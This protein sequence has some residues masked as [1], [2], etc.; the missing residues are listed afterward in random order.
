MGID[1][2]TPEAMRPEDWVRVLYEYYQNRML[3]IKYFTDEED[4]VAVRALEATL[5]PTI[6]MYVDTLTHAEVQVIAK[7]SPKLKTREL[8]AELI[9][10][11]IAYLW[12]QKHKTQVYSKSEYERLSSLLETVARALRKKDEPQNGN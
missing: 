2:V 5:W 12:G 8:S 11:L 6:Q 10:Q 1:K 4:E 7:Q 3:A 9:V